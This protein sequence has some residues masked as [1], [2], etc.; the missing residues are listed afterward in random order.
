MSFEFEFRVGVQERNK[1]GRAASPFA[2]ALGIGL[3]SRKVR[4]V[5]KVF[6]LSLLGDLEVRSFGGGADFVA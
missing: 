1:V 5:R 2:A 6:L 3:G 4:E